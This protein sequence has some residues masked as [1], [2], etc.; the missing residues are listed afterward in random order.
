MP[1]IDGVL[2]AD[3]KGSMIDIVQAVGRALRKPRQIKDKT[4]YIIIPIRFH[5]DGSYVEDDF[6]PLHTVIQALRDQDDTLAEWIDE[7]NWS[8][9]KG[10]GGT[11]LRH[12]ASKV[13]L[14][15]P[16]SVDPEKF[17]N[18]LTIRIATVNSRVAGQIGLGSTLGKKQRGSDYKRI[19][20]SM[21]WVFPSRMSGPTAPPPG[22]SIGLCLTICCCFRNISI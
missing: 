9:V 18:D 17:A 16:A 7:I 19:F 12:K 6:A 2:F 15:V 1:F 3:S 21:A 8:V 13:Q 22:T 20:K 10:T 4:S 5:S 14:I 11:A